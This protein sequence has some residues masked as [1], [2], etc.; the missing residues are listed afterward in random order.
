M[1]EPNSSTRVNQSALGQVDTHS[2]FRPTPF[3]KRGRVAEK[4][5]DAQQYI[6][7]YIHPVS[8]YNLETSS[9]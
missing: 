9:V 4:S 8:I 6:T 3:Q 7:E 2:V 5:H 1:S